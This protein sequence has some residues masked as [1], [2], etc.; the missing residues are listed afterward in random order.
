MKKLLVFLCIVCFGSISAQAN[1]DEK[2]LGEHMISL[3]W[4]SWDYF[5]KAVIGKTETANEYTI[6]GEQKSK[7]NSDYLKIDGT[8]KT[9]SETELKFTGIIETFISHINNGEACR[10]NGIFTFKVKGKR[11]YWRMQEIDN[12]CDGVADYVDIYFKQ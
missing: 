8:L 3:Q 10:R 12:P 5:G 9:I 4:I 6:K 7:E 11:K 1:F 2:L